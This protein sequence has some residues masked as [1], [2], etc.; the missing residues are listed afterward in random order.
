MHHYKKYHLLLILAT[1][2]SFASSFVASA[3]SAVVVASPAPSSSF[4]SQRRLLAADASATAATASSN[5]TEFQWRL[6]AR[7]STTPSTFLSHGWE[8]FQATCAIPLFN[9]NAFAA[10]ISHLAGQTIRV[11]GISADFMH[12][13]KSANVS[14]PCEFS[15]HQPFTNTGQCMFSTGAFDALLTGLRRAGVSML[16][17]LNELIGRNCTQAVEPHIHR[18]PNYD[19]MSSP[20]PD[21]QHQYCG[22]S[23]LPWDTEPLR[24]LLTHVRDATAVG[25]AATATA[26]AT[27]TAASASLSAGGGGG[28]SSGK[29]VGFELGNEL[30]APKHLPRDVAVS[31]I[32]QLG[33]LFRE[34][35]SDPSQYGHIPPLYATGTNDCSSNNNSDILAAVESLDLPVRGFSFHNYPGNR[36]TWWNKSDLASY[37]LNTSWLRTETLRPVQPCLSAWNAGPRDRNVPAFVTEGAAMCGGSF[38]SGAPTTTSFIHGFFSVAQLGQ[39]ARAGIGMIARWGIPD[40][41]GTSGLPTPYATWTPAL[42]AHDYWFYIL[43]NTTMGAGVIDTGEVLAMENDDAEMNQI[44]NNNQRQQ[45]QNQNQNQ[46]GNNGNRRDGRSATVASASSSLALVYAHCATP[47]FGGSRNGSVTLMAANPTASPVI[48]DITG[49]QHPTLPRL[50]YVLTP[51]K[52]N[53]SA[54]AP[55]LNARSPALV[56]N[57]SGALPPMPPVYC[58]SSSSSSSSSN[59]DSSSDNGV[60]NGTCGTKITLPPQSQAFFV[61]LHAAHK[62]CMQ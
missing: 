62:D 20:K 5:T 30:F 3:S 6:G 15:V 1:L 27:A 32:G 45:N 50:E 11:G 26:T 24:M 7:I 58:S 53:L 17:D 56:L 49:Q 52:G 41:L 22:D 35:W 51:P 43:Y 60:E 18:E 42:V 34:I 38:E 36:Q 59:G 19:M 46:N 29:L 39:Y 33:A 37:L 21:H 16:F 4:S 55:L 14:A 61:L 9:N 23:P 25:E 57:P 44:R 8:S 31:D 40:L 28:S 47:A 12:Y 2:F 13:I 48:L 10:T 54:H